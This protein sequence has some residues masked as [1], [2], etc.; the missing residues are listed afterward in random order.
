MHRH[1][2][3]RTL[4]FGVGCKEEEAFGNSR[5]AKEVL[6]RQ[7]DKIG[8]PL[9]S[10]Q[11]K[12]AA[13][14]RHL[15]PTL[16]SETRQPAE[17][18]AGR[19]PWCVREKEREGERGR[20]YSHQD[21]GHIRKEGENKVLN[22]DS[23]SLFRRHSKDLTGITSSICTLSVRLEILMTTPGYY[24]KEQSSAFWK[25]VPLVLNSPYCYHF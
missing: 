7:T 13:H 18:K 21:S 12:T 11:V 4:H 24:P 10:R 23:L 25:K 14:N 20:A 9:M 6:M 19:G 8:G 15:L 5:S 16:Q 17:C 22:R 1:T 3:L 2:G